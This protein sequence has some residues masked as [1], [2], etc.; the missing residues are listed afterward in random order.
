MASDMRKYQRL[1]LR[2]LVFYF[3]SL[4]FWEIS[5]YSYRQLLQT[6]RLNK[7]HELGDSKQN[8]KT[9]VENASCK[10]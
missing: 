3:N 8:L 4:V 1:S 9:E 6:A 5:L 7:Q 10:L 2:K